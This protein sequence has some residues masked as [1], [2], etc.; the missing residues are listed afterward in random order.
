MVPPAFPRPDV[1]VTMTGVLEVLGAI[2]LFLSS[3]APAAS[4]CL[5]MLLVALF[6]ANIHAAR[7]HLTFAGQ[8]VPGLPMRTAIQLVFIS[9]LTAVA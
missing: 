5:A 4:V 7:Q 6:P 8:R 1:L 3:T 2:G 9:A